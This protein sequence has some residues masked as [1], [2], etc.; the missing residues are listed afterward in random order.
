MRERLTDRQL[1][2]CF[3]LVTP[4]QCGVG[5]L[6]EYKVSSSPSKKN[7]HVP[8]AT[9]SAGCCRAFPID[10]LPLLAT[11]SSRYSSQLAEVAITANTIYQEFLNSPEGKRFNGQVR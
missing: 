8:E 3:L 1:V 10:M 4:Q 11:E 7:R 9:P 2:Y 5:L 6:P